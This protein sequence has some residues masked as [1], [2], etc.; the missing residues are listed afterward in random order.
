MEEEKPYS[1]S[2]KVGNA[3]RV[4]LKEYTRKE[5]AING[6]NFAV[7]KARRESRKDGAIRNVRME[8]D[9]TGSEEEE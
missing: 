2:M 7:S 5:L 4:V 1:V 8:F 9:I 6:F 3:A